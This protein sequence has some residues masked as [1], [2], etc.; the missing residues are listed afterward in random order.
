[1]SENGA[2]KIDPLQRR[3]GDLATARRPI[4]DRSPLATRKARLLAKNRQREHDSGAHEMASRR[5][6]GCGAGRRAKYTPSSSWR[7]TRIPLSRSNDR[8]CRSAPCR[9]RRALPRRGQNM[10]SWL[11]TNRTRVALISTVLSSVS[12]GKFGSSQ[13]RR[14]EGAEKGCVQQQDRYP[15]QGRGRQTSHAEAGAGFFREIYRCAPTVIS[16]Y[17]GLNRQHQGSQEAHSGR[18]WNGLSTNQRFPP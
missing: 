2:S 6:A 10:A 17:D 5:R 14:S 11:T 4:R 16:H 7:H 1:M 3:R 13:A 12:G 9:P 18:R 15:Q 8:R